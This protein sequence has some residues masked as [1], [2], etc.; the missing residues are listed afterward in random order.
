ME[1]G[2]VFFCVRR[3]K[4]EFEEG[5]EWEGVCWVLSSFVI[6]RVKDFVFG[7]CSI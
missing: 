7:I 5:L 2:E 6:L 3:G 1:V 4:R